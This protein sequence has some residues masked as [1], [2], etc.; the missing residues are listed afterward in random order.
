MIKGHISKQNELIGFCTIRDYFTV[1][2]EVIERDDGALS[3][4]DTILA[5]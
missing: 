5:V 4:R 2:V 1:P 3:H